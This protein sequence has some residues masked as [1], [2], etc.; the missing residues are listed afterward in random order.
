LFFASQASFVDTPVGLMHYSAFMQT[1]AGLR[2]LFDLAGIAIC[3]GLYIVPLYAIMQHYSDSAYRARTIATNNVMNAL[4]MVAS[5]LATVA[6]LKA[7]FSVPQVFLTVGAL[8][9]LVA[10]YSTKLR[11]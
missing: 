6:M 10:W 5:A 7:H 3:G 2:I 4:F 8:N 1:A 9:A 11:A